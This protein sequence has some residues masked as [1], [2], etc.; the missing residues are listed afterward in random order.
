MEKN[1]KKIELLAGS[2]IEAAVT[3]LTKYKNRGEF[4]YC[5]F[6]GHTL[7]SDSATIDSAYL[8]IIGKSKAESEKDLEEHRK[9]YNQEVEE[10][11]SR[12]PEL[13]KY[14]IEKGHT[15]LNEKYWAEWDECVPI[16]LNDLYKGLE[17][18]CCLA[19]I[20]RLNNGCNLEEAKK[21]I[22]EQ[23]HSGI[24]FHLV[25]SMVGSFCDRGQDFVRFVDPQD[26]V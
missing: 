12:I 21:I 4:A 3:E 20:E 8:E 24:S 2:S 16:R 22:E 13:T 15:I 14:W 10:H 6:N 9:K 7:Y 11:K 17:L 19:I 26:K 5:S 23:N 18:K 25:K 1:Y